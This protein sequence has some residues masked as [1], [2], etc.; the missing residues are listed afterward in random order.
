MTYLLSCHLYLKRGQEINR[1][2]ILLNR[3]FDFVDTLPYNIYKG[4]D[5][6]SSKIIVLEIQSKDYVF[7]DELIVP[8]TVKF[9]P[10]KFIAKA[11][12]F[13]EISPRFV[14]TW[15]PVNKKGEGNIGS[16]LSLEEISKIRLL[17]RKKKTVKQIQE[18][19]SNVSISTIQRVVTKQTWK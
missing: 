12:F 3:S 10:L 5:S 19:F 15:F 6:K 13:I 8:L 14:R 4:H 16:K 11:N 18:I 17:F 1:G 7:L 9:I 2:I